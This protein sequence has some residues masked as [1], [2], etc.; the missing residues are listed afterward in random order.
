MLIVGVLLIPLFLI[1]L[2]IIFKFT[3][4]KEGK[5][6]RGEEILN[7]SN[8]VTVPILPIGWLLLEIAH[9][10]FDISYSLYR[11]SLWVLVLINFI[12]HG[13][14]I[15]FYKNNKHQASE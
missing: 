5:G 11:D 12:V 7:K 9:S 2:Y 4:G 15:Y 6:E 14:A 8:R 1:S 10:I 13:L 3:W